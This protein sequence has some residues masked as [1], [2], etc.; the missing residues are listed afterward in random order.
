MFRP[1]TSYSLGKCSPRIAEELAKRL[2]VPVGDAYNAVEAL[3]REYPDLIMVKDH[4]RKPP[5]DP[6]IPYVP[7]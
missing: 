5:A 7:T 4:N 2:G 1:S 6:A 3:A